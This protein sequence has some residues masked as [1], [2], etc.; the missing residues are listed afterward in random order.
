MWDVVY[1]SFKTPIQLLSFPLYYLRLF[2]TGV[3]YWSF[4]EMGD[5]VRMTSRTG[6]S[7]R[8]LRIWRKLGELKLDAK[9]G[10][11]TFGAR[12]GETN[13]RAMGAAQ[14]RWP[15]EEASIKRL[16]LSPY[17]ET[18]NSKVIKGF[19]TWTKKSLRVFR[20]SRFLCSKLS[21]SGYE[22][23]E[24]SMYDS[25]IAVSGYS[26]QS[27][28]LSTDFLALWHSLGI[29]LSFHFLLFLHYSLPV[30]I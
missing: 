22:H 20:I 7:R 28:L 13:L 21:I 25:H 15:D 5:W 24:H 1:K 8:I 19:R 17:V 6:R 30:K 16:C 4:R 27:P 29:Y 9:W 26:T 2:D 3:N 18:F 11:S 23:Y 12:W 14:D 10:G